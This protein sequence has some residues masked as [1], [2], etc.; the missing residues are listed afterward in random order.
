MGRV[1]IKEPVREPC[2]VGMGTG[3]AAEHGPGAG[4]SIGRHARVRPLKRFE[5]VHGK[6]GDCDVGVYRLGMTTLCGC[7]TRWYRVNFDALDDSRAF[8]HFLGGI[9]YV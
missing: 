1:S 7:E 2:L 5:G 6:N 9:P 4:V 8:F 3:K